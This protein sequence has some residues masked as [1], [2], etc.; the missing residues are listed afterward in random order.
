MVCSLHAQVFGTRKT[1][2]HKQEVLFGLNVLNYHLLPVILRKKHL[3]AAV[4]KVKKT[5]TSTYKPRLKHIYSVQASYINDLN[6]TT[7]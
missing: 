7:L 2:N 6:C 5:Q 4:L 1:G 3:S